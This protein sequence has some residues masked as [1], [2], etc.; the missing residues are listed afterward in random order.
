[1]FFCVCRV[2]TNVCGY[3]EEKDETAF[4]LV[5]GGWCRLLTL[6]GDIILVVLLVDG[7]RTAVNFCTTG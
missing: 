2:R 5:V 4:L 6:I 1:M 7:L 3:V